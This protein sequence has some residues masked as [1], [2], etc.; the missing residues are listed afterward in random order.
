MAGYAFVT[1]TGPHGIRALQ[2]KQRVIREMQKHNADDAKHNERMRERNQ[3]LEASPADQELEIRNQ[4]KM[5]RPDEKVFITGQ[6]DS[7]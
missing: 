7:H 5:V 4:L 2:E 6:P 3:R 1:L